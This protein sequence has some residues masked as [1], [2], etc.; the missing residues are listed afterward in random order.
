MPKLTLRA[1][2]VNQGLTQEQAAELLDVTKDIVSNWE[3]FKTF[4]DVKDVKKIE[5]VYKVSYN[6]LIFLPEESALSVD[7]AD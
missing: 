6:D 3:R 2:R 7:S 4:P 5:S 1:A